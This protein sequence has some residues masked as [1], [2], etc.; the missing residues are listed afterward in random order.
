MPNSQLPVF[1]TL[2]EAQL[3]ALREIVTNGSPA[4]PRNFRTLEILHRGFSLS[5]PRQRRL[6]LTSR[7]WN[8]A[9]AIAE[10]CWHTS[11]SDDVDA[12]AY[13]AP[14]WRDFSNDQGRIKGSCY[15]K[16]IFRER[17]GG[18]SQWEWVI[19]LLRNDPHTRRAIIDLQGPN[20]LQESTS[21]DVSCA[22]SLQFFVR[23]NRLHASVAMRSNDAIWGLPY[24]VYLFTMLQELMALH[25][26]IPIGNY[27]HFASSL[28]LYDHHMHLATSMLEHGL[29]PSV[30]MP[31]MELPCVDE[32]RALERGL[33]RGH[34]VNQ[35]RHGQF[36]ESV[37]GPLT[38]FAKN[39][40]KQEEVA[41]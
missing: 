9:L 1:E 35:N 37:S 29:T 26:D 24:D 32:L 4:S 18:R 14:R 28:H 39:R 38:A 41:T 5:N 16:R 15:G 10:F 7:R 34:V 31:P 6:T 20:L 17:R 11:G 23:S 33:R 36:W 8:E 25:L 12:L 13:Y 3:W 22:T 40:L 27:T 21:Q 2:D 30:P 19:D